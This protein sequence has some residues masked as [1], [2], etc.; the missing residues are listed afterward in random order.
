LR[1]RHFAR[2]AAVRRHRVAESPET[3][4]REEIFDRDNWICGICGIPTDRSV[5]H[6]E[7][8][9]PVLDHIV[10]ISADGEHVRSN[11][12]CAHSRCN[13]LKGAT[14]PDGVA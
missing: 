13:T 12:Q 8:Y 7:P 6:P 2:K 14:I 4:T 5:C 3:F 1:K 11:V 9:A 10:P